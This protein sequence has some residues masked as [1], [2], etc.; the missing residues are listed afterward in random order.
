MIMPKTQA[1]QAPTNAASNGQEVKRTKCPVTKAQMA[2]IAPVMATLSLPGVGDR[3]VILGPKAPFKTGS[4]GWHN[5]D[6]VAAVV[7]G[8]A[9]KVQ[10]NISLVIVDSKNAS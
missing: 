5:N 8:V 1:S 10:V 3:S 7:D 6:K 9:C 2:G 4:Y